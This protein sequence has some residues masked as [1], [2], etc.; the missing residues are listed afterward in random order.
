MSRAV[1]RLLASSPTTSRQTSCA[2]VCFLH[3]GQTGRPMLPPTPPLRASMMRVL[4][5]ALT[6]LLLM[7]AAVAPTTATRRDPDIIVVGGGTAGCAIAA[8]LCAA[9]PSLRVVLLE[10]G[11]PRNATEEFL[12]RSPRQPL[13]SWELPSLLEAFLTAEE[14]TLGGRRIRM[15]MGATLG[16]GSAVNIGQ[17]TEPLDGAVGSWGVDGLSDSLARRFFRRAARQIG[18]AVPRKELRQEYTD[19][20]LAA[21]ARAG[22]PTISDAGWPQ[23]DHGAWVHRLAVDAAGRRRDACTAYVGPALRGAC[24]RNLQVRQGVTVSKF[25]WDDNMASIEMEARGRRRL[26]KVTGVVYVASTDRSAARKRTLRARRAVISTAGAVGSPALLQRSGIGPPTVL[27]RAGV[28]PRVDLPVG[29]RF[30]TRPLVSITHRYSGVPLA[31]ENNASALADPAARQ[32]WEAGRGGVYGVAAFAG[33]GRVSDRDGGYI[34]ATFT[35]NAAPG[36]PLFRTYCMTNTASTGRLSVADDIPFTPPTVETNLLSERG[37]VATMLACLRRVSA[38]GDAFA[39]AFAMREIEPGQRPLDEAYVRGSA[40]SSAHVVG[41]C[42]VGTVLDGQLRVRGFHNLYVVDS[43]AIPTIPPS[44]GTMA[45]VYMLAEF[46]AARLAR[47][48]RPRGG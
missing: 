4:L 42:S 14:K 12:V 30:T 11:A 33:L 40:G 3:S 46:A 29:M 24:A 34:S 16:G 26:R 20:W 37:E 13:S 28:T 7:L 19:D 48:F 47:V 17:W 8:R 22:L 18:V 5:C 1:V 15:M 23:A 21:A 25:L 38:V 9:L 39:P 31:V 6:A 32:R 35:T 44:A 45:S 10:R 2:L 43:S 27:R 41:G 36:A